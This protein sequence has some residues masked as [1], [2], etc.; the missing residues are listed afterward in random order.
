M[1]ENFDEGL[2]D[3]YVRAALAHKRGAGLPLA[4]M[5]ATARRNRRVRAAS[6]SV[7]SVAAVAAIVVGSTT[8]LGAWGGGGGTA[9]PAVSTEPTADPSP[10]EVVSLCGVDPAGFVPDEG[11]PVVVALTTEVAGADGQ[12]AGTVTVRDGVTSLPGSGRVIAIVAAQDGAVVAQGSIV[13]PAEDQFDTGAPADGL[14]FSAALS[15]CDTPAPGQLSSGGYDVYIVTVPQDGGAPIVLGGSTPL[16]V[17][18]LGDGKLPTPDQQMAGDSSATFV[19]GE[20]LADGNYVG[21]VVDIDAANGTVDVDLAVFLTGAAAQDWAAKN[22]PGGEVLDDYVLVDDAPRSTTL[23]I[24]ADAPVLEW[25]FQSSDTEPLSYYP[26]T[27]AQ[28]AAAPRLG[29]TA[30]PVF[31]CAD[32]DR[33]SVG[34]LYWF[35][36]RGGVVVQ[37]VGQY[38]P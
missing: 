4:T 37:V 25:C 27:V 33:L 35:D 22:N 30:T 19:E 26:R 5:A 21:H 23:P 24:D 16:T 11:D 14:A 18:P 34:S 17:I 1:S 13:L 31:A 8:A 38:V 10:V 32:G 12:V 15:P 36:V 6:M 2:Q 28:W 9:H 3:L 7:A 20:P 29:G